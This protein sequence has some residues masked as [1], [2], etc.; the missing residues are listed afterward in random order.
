MTKKYVMDTESGG[1]DILGVYDQ[2]GT[3][4]ELVFY[5]R[6]DGSRGQA[7][8]D[9]V[10]IVEA[11]PSGAPYVTVLEMGDRVEISGLV[12]TVDSAGDPSL[13]PEEEG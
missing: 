10:Q 5:H 9:C 12:Y 2:A 11:V 6:P 7:P 13:V 4:K 8:A 3:D 1:E